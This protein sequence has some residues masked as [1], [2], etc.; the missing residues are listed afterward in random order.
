MRSEIDHSEIDYHVKEKVV[1][2]MFPTVNHFI[3][4]DH[5][6][7]GC[8]LH[9]KGLGPSGPLGPLGPLGKGPLGKGPL[10]KG[11]SAKAP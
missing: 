8:L 10:G 9:F 7:S 3:T 11:P 4:Q 2:I 5:Y 1:G 6:I